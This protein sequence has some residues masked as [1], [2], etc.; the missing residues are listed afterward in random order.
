MNRLARIA[1]AAAIAMTA[2]SGLVSPQAA[3]AAYPG[4]NG[5]IVFSSNRAP[6]SG[7][8]LFTMTATGGSVTQRT[9]GNVRDRDPVF[10]PGGT[11]IAF[12]RYSTAS[13]ASGEIYVMNA[14]GSGLRKLTNNFDHDF[15][16]SFRADGALIAFSSDRM[17][18]YDLF[19]MNLDG[20][21]VTQIT[22][23][24]T[25]D[26]MPAYFAY[27]LDRVYY[28]TTTGGP[29]PNTDRH[30]RQLVISLH[31]TGDM[32]LDTSVS[33]SDTYPDAYPFF[34]PLGSS[35][36]TFERFICGSGRCWT[37]V[38]TAGQ[39]LPA[40]GGPNLER[41]PAFSPDGDSIW[42]SSNAND[43]DPHD[44]VNVFDIWR[45]NSDGTGRT[46]VTSN[47][48]SI[49][50]DPNVQPIPDFPLVDAR[51]SSFDGS[52]QAVVGAGIASG[53]D[54]ELYCPASSI[55][56]SEMAAFLDRAL[57]LPDATQDYFTDDQN[58]AFED[59][60]NRVREAGIA[61]GCTATTFCP[62]EGVMRGEMAAFLD[63]AL[64][65]PD[66][67]QDYFTDDQNLAFEDSINRVREAEIAFGCGF[68][69]FCP[70]QAVTRG[71]MAA[72]LDR[73]F[74]S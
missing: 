10:S 16:P 44:S 22:S 47:T 30:I 55:K 73:A 20:I 70:D 43:P 3:S 68:D 8:H 35:S 42:Y 4:A 33:R 51:F 38:Q 26:M 66:A 72:F 67:T 64:D 48:S 62:N 39:P 23:N 69:T 2:A 31:A 52:I 6:G 21:G 14:D 60:I 24:T 74:V 15:A 9:F 53:C 56:R 65:L 71:Q 58:L 49:S 34:D 46:R 59:S 40:T 50:L 41:G 18:N 61:F 25:D 11:R 5:L 27:D 45:M 37:E 32:S 13:Q 28:S 1:I 57:D 17:G 19:A 7:I 12:T 29:G 63:R 54:Q 36:V